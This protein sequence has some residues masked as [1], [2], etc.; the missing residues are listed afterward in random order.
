MGPRARRMWERSNG[1]PRANQ[2]GQVSAGMQADEVRRILGL[3]SQSMLGQALPG[4]NRL[5]GLAGTN[6]VHNGLQTGNAMQ[7]SR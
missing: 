5:A 2:A 4:V 7:L 1:Q 3:E 6:A